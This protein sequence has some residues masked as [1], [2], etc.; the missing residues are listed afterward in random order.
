MFVYKEL[1]KQNFNFIRKHIK[2]NS[3]DKVKFLLVTKIIEV[4]KLIF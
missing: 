1:M 2:K 3:S 4:E